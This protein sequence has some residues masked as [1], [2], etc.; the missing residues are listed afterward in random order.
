VARIVK[1][2]EVSHMGE[3]LVELA[4]DYGTPWMQDPAKR[5]ALVELKEKDGIRI[6]SKEEY[7]KLL[8]D[9]IQFFLCEEESKA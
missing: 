1:V 2:G 3:T 8:P 5:K 7:E 9:A 4:F 6:L